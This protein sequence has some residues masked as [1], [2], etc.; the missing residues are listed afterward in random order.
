MAGEP[1]AYILGMREFYGL[2]FRVTPAVLIPRPETELL[3]DLALERMPEGEP[4]DVLDIG[5]GSGCIA[6]AIARL[7][8]RARVLAIDV[9]AEALE[10]ARENAACLQVANVELRQSD[11]WQS[12]GDARFHLVVANPPYIA[13]AD[14]HLAHGD[15]RFEP[16]LALTPGADGL[17]MI[18]RIC[19]AAKRHLH[20]GGWLLLEHGHDQAEAVAESMR[21]GGLED[22]AHVQ[23]LARIPRVA[24][25]RAPLAAA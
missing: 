17:S 4:L 15:L 1:V 20:G 12:V 25:A 16:A 21:A 3:V 19:E 8:S 22:I 11:G 18:R 10:V 23:D 24:L 9:S 5:T 6:M 14:P 2:E 7:R 13:A